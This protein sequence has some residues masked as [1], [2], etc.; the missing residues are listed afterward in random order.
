MS[1]RTLL[2]LISTII[3]LYFF[4]AVVSFRLDELESLPLNELG[5]FLAGAF[6]PLALTWLVFGYFQQGAELKQ[7]TNALLLQAEELKSSVEQ[8]TEMVE[9]QKL[10]VRNYE[11]SLEPLLKM[12]HNGNRQLE[13]EF[14]ESFTVQNLGHYCESIKVDITVDGVT[15]QGFELQPLFSGDSS[16]FFVDLNEKDAEMLIK[17]TRINGSCGAQAFKVQHYFD[18]A[19]GPAIRVVKHSFVI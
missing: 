4:S 13:G 19:D 17:Y 14:Y 2:A 8:Q 15:R 18:D 16:G 6:G 9:S 7:G 12:T 1:F 10:S 5:D 3:Y 11:R